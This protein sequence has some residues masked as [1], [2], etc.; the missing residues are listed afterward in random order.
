MPEFPNL[1]SIEQ[2]LTD[3][4]ARPGT[5][6]ERLIREN[7]DFEMLRPEEF[8]DTVG[9]PPWLRIHWRKQHPD[10]TYP[11]D[12][13]TGGYPRALKNLHAWMLVHQDL[14]PEAEQIV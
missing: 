5:A 4:D 6:L 2:Q 12:D 14:R 1:P 3:A 7:Q 10:V 13:P 9:I 11:S 8:S